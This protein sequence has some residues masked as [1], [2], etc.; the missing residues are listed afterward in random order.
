[1]RAVLD[2]V[3]IVLDLYVWLLIASA[4]LMPMLFVV[5]HL[6]VLLQV[7]LLARTADAYNQAL[8]RSVAENGDRTLIRQRLAMLCV[9]A[10]STRQA[11]TNTSEYSARPRKINGA[12]TALKTPPRT[13]PTDIHR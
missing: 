2:I 4:I 11:R 12:T 8:D 1:M 6:Y 5:Y 10:G 3:L 13:P 7:V 9:G